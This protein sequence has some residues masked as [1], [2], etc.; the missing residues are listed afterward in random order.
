MVNDDRDASLTRTD[1]IRVRERDCGG[2]ECVA[3]GVPITI[4]LA[5]RDAH[6]IG[7]GVIC[8]TGGG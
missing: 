8:A 4:R 2:T 5:R 1:C 6:S 3:V 7:F